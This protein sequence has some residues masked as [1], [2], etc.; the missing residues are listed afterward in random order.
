MA[1]TDHSPLVAQEPSAFEAAVRARS[2]DWL[3]ELRRRLK[4]DLQLIDN[5]NTCLLPFIAAGSA[6]S[7]A[8]LWEQREPVVLSAVSNALQARGPQAV[9]WQGL[10]VICVPLTADRSSPG[11]LVVARQLS[12]G[13]DSDASRGQ[14]ELVGSWLSTAVEAHL[15]SPPAF[16][17]SGL[18]RVAP[19]SRLLSRAAESESDREIVRL[20]GEA[21][22]VWHDIEVSGYIDSGDGTFARDVTL[23]GTRKGER[24]AS[25]PG[26][27]LPDT[28][29]PTRLP[30]GHLDRFGLPVNND[31]YVS[32]LRRSGGRAWL[33]VFTGTIG[34]Y[35]LQRLDAYASLL[36]VALALASA[37]TSSHVVSAITRSL[38]DDDETPEVR[39]GHALEELRTAIGAASARLTIESSTGVVLLRASTPALAHGSHEDDRASHLVV[40]NRSDRHYTTTV[41]IE[42]TESLQFTPRDHDVVSAA[43]GVLNGWAPTA[44]RV[45][46]RGR[47]RRT[48]S[49]G[50]QEL[51]ERSAREAV[52][53]GMPVT[54]VVL[55]VRDAVYLP[56]STQ[57][58]VAGMRGQMRPSDLAGMLAE[59][60][61]GLLMHDT[62]AQ[63]A[64]TI[65][66]RLRA[67][68]GGP[69]DAG[70]ILIGVATRVPGLG[71][72]DGIVR[73]AH[74]DA[75]T[76]RSTTD[77]KTA[78]VHEVRR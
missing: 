46:V 36:D 22:A 78:A 72:A 24:P 60:E 35:D 64:K 45:P 39:A 65:A 23:P 74:A 25:I 52:E 75:L 69:S 49:P 37:E 43:A 68:V 41:S 40:V 71:D 2:W 1:V 62:T 12:P 17:A 53:R 63:H 15:V 51:M 32:L 66:A 57:R 44:L 47:D 73:E 59:G 21:V 31:V 27:G 28:P 19:L 38:S 29:E 26:A 18:N 55:L 8:G 7:L 33:L 16:H 3:V 67:V 42:R 11:A 50:F 77:M 76:L 20:F 4:V 61:I 34:A 58:W 54:A 70:S 13:Q 30:Q 5:R 14:L 9:T 56:G 10:Q 6:P 48:V